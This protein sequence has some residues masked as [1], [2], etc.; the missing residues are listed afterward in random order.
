MCNEA[1]LGKGVFAGCGRIVV[2]VDPESQT[3]Q[4]LI[5]SGLGNTNLKAPQ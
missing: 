3:Y 2:T 4:S 5:E 1:N